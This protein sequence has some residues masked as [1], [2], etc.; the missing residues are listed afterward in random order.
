M[1]KSTSGI[2]LPLSSSKRVPKSTFTVVGQVSRSD[3]VNG[4]IFISSLRQ[5]KVTKNLDYRNEAH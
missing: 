1:G 4:R 5:A 3:S 2:M